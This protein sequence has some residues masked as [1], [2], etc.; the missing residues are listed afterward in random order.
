VDKRGCEIRAGFHHNP[1]D[2]LILR[3]FVD[4]VFI[5]CAFLLKVL[6]SSFSLRFLQKSVDSRK[7]L[8]K[9][10]KRGIKPSLT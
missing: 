3:E 1:A 10:K 6:V 5:I 8:I 7:K 9:R 4:A 2:N